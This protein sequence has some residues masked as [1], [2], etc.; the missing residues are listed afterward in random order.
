MTQSLETLPPEEGPGEEPDETPTGRPGPARAAKRWPL[1][2]LRT[3]VC[4]LTLLMLIQPVLAGQFITG[5][6]DLLDLHALN[7]TFIS[8]V[9]WI[10][11]AAAVTLWRPGGGPVWPIGVTLLVAGLVEA[12]S[13]FG[14]AR[15]LAVHIP[16]GVALVAGMTALGYWVFTYRP[17]RPRNES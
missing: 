12:Q 16:L 3:L 15:N 4:A 17:G 5:D 6:S 7:A 1:V 11:V 8:A 9:S 13:G 2:V 10:L 14:Y